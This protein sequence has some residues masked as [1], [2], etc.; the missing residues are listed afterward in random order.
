MGQIDIAQFSE[1][2]QV[3]VRAH[4]LAVNDNIMLSGLSHNDPKALW[5]PHRIHGECFMGL[6]NKA[7]R[8]E[9]PSLKS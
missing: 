8:L 5:P 7:N 4:V 3:E 2:M 9:F 1:T 6:S